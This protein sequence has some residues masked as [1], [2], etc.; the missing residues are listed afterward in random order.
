[1][2]YHAP[3]LKIVCHTLWLILHVG[4]YIDFGLGCCGSGLI[5][6]GGMWAIAH[7]L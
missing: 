3:S 2:V 6:T 4:V 5:V 7:A 1:M